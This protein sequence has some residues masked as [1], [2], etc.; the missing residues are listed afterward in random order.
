MV[1]L[2]SLRLLPVPPRYPEKDLD[3]NYC[4]NPDSS[5]GPWCYT[6]DPAREREYCHLRKCSKCCV[7]GANGSIWDVLTTLLCSYHR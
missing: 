3:D 7:V 5:V 4:R 1:S 6:T 2:T